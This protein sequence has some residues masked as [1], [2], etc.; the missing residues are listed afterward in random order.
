VC[1]WGRHG[2]QLGQAVAVWAEE[3]EEAAFR[4]CSVQGVSLSSIDAVEVARHS[5]AERGYPPWR[6]A[7]FAS[8]TLLPRFS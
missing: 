4:F 2:R 5:R 6:S 8:T 7:P 3:F 1:L